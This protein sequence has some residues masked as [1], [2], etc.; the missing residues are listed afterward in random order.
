MLYSFFFLSENKKTPALMSGFQSFLAPLF[1]VAAIGPKSRQGKIRCNY[2]W[3]SM[4]MSIFDISWS[5]RAVT[6]D[7]SLLDVDELKGANPK[8]FYGLILDQ[9]TTIKK[10]FSLQKII[11]IF[12]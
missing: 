10:I 2:P 11:Q 8:S 6:V 9:R 3:D 4:N 1:H 7:S 12:L 5:V